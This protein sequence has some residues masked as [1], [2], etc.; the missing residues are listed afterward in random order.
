MKKSLLIIL[1]F[2]YAFSNAQISFEKGY[3]ISNDGTRT[4]CFIKNLDW[5]NT[6]TE[7]KYKLQLNDSESKVETISAV[8]EFGIENES[9][10]KRFKVQIDRTSDEVKNLTTNENP[11]W[12][13]ETIFLKILVEGDAANLYEY[14]GEEIKRFFYQTPNSK[15]EQLIYLRYISE[16]QNEG[17]QNITQ[18]N[19]YQK[20]LFDNVRCGNTTPN[21]IRKLTY[22][23]PELTNYFIEYNKCANPS[24]LK[25]KT[26]T[27][28]GELFLRITPSINFVSLNIPD[29]NDYNLNVDANNKT[30]FK[31]GFEGEYIL[32]YNKNKWSVFIDP[33]YQKYEN[34][35]PY[36]VK[37]F[38]QNTKDVIYHAKIEYSSVEIPVGVRHYMFLNKTSKL[39]I[40]LAY[41]FDVNGKATISYDQTE[42]YHS[43]TGPNFAFG[44]GYNYKNTVSLEMRMNTA[45]DL[46]ADYP[47]SDAN[48]KSFSIILG[49]KIL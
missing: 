14:T 43:R 44:F 37:S 32:P 40:N 9:T 21:D 12:T 27:T 7:F 18:N 1:F 10:Y 48:Y 36:S 35:S 4:E 33:T 45:K 30:I 11:T 29:R 19:A 47:N 22:K 15:L 49:Y 20:Q 23:R 5:K 41:V 39:F 17:T 46:L 2:Y 25:T 6:P 26:K 34:E 8:Q 24:G 28:K 16:L 42:Y 3:F 38:F 31:I 13:E